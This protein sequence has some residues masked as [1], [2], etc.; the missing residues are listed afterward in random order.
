MMV[1]GAQED[2]AQRCQQHDPRLHTILLLYIGLGGLERNVR[3]A[4]R[5]PSTMNEVQH[6]RIARQKIV[7]LL[8]EL[9]NEQE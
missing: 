3:H 8:E 1:P 7:V 2:A 4:C 6:G 5:I 9:Y